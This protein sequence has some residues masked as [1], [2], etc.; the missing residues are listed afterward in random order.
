MNSSR[1]IKMYNKKRAHRGRAAVGKSV[2]S[3][4]LFALVKIFSI[5]PFYEEILFCFTMVP[6]YH[7]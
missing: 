5:P 3:S 1:A 4:P 2:L 6:R 7:D